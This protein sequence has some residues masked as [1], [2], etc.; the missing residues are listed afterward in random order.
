MRSLS[1]RRQSKVGFLQEFLAGIPSQMM[2]HG[3]WKLYFDGSANR[4]GAGAGIL[5]EVPNG[6]VTTMCKRLLFPVTKN[7]AEY[8][9]CIM[10]IESLL[11]TSSKEVEVIGDSLLVIEHASERR[12]V[13][14]YRLK[15][16]IEYLLKKAAAALF[17]KITFTHI[18]RN[19]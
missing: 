17:D 16:Y 1:Q 14:E 3:V 5:I 4:N 12:K 19:S 15:P 6:E 9:A 13:E 18:S 10:G 2:N 8:E 11:A 7:M